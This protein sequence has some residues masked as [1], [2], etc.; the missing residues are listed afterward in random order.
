MVNGTSFIRDTPAGNAM[1]VR[2]TGSMRLQKTVCEPHRA[3]K[4]VGGFKFVL[5]DEDVAAVAL[6]ER[7]AAP[8]ADEIRDVR[9]EQASDG[10]RYRD[11]IQTEA[12]GG[13]QVAR[14]RHD[15]FGGQRNA[16]A[17][18]RHHQYHPAVTERQIVAMMRAESPETILSSIFSMC[19]Y[20]ESA[21]AQSG[22]AWRRLRD[23]GQLKGHAAALDSKCRILVYM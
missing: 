4:V 18:D 10:P 15:D 22:T 19:S 3:K 6:D 7:A 11:H 16:C 9:A 17:F 13:D 12:A 8:G 2:T 14:E 20:S 23:D 1:K 5:S 21:S